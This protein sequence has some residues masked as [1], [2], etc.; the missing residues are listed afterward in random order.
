MV[1]E[2]WI[3]ILVFDLEESFFYWLW[4][5]LLYVK[6]IRFSLIQ[7]KGSLRI[8]GFIDL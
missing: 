8:L 7:K 2:Y 5:Y 1:F 3:L 6:R 4:I